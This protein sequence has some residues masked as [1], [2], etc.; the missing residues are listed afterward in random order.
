M[1]KGNFRKIKGKKVCKK[2]RL[3]KVSIG[4]KAITVDQNHTIRSEVIMLL[5]AI[6]LDKIP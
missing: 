4:S 5:E 1:Q 3:F 2:G 6:I